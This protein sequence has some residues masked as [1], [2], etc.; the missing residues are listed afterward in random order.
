MQ[1]PL[2]TKSFEGVSSPVYIDIVQANDV[3]VKTEKILVQ[4]FNDTTSQ[5]LTSETF[6]VSFK[7]WKKITATVD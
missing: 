5:S 4:E 6:A 3:Y 7:L 2:C 1:S